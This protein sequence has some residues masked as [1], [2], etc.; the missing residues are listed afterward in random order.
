MTAPSQLADLSKLCGWP[1][2]GSNEA[3][4]SLAHRFNKLPCMAAPE[5]PGPPIWKFAK[6]LLGAHIPWWFQQSDDCVSMGATQ[7]GQ[8]LSAFNIM[9]NRLEQKFRLWF[10]PWIYGTSRID[11]GK[12]ELGR[13]GGS[14]GSW[15]VEAMR[16]CGVLFKDDEGV[17]AYSKAIAE[18]WGMGVPKTFYPLAKDNP[19]KE[20]SRL[21]TV[22]EIRLSLLNYRP[23]TYAI[24]WDYEPDR[25]KEVKGYRTI[26]RS[27]YLGGHQ[28]CLLA[29][30][31]EP[32]EAAFLLNSWGKDAHAGVTSEL[33]E[34]PGGGWVPRKE[35]ERDM[36]SGDTECYALSCFEG[37]P[38]EPWYG[39]FGQGGI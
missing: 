13:G 1:E 3:F 38:G 28:I 16:T 35:L 18:K 2:Q 30:M 4:A 36:A 11:I 21:K 31:D 10:P 5:K 27:R 22:D 17:P 15:A 20:A 14:F 23:C 8:Y 29:W 33:D 37:D 25:T 24:R 26:Y 7:A 19:V 9:V 6:E 39:V 34:P 32:F 12:G